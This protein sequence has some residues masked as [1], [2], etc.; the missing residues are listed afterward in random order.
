[1]AISNKRAGVILL[2]SVIAVN[3]LLFFGFSWLYAQVPDG[4]LQSTYTNVATIG[5]VAAGLSMVG[6][7]M[8]I[9]NGKAMMQARGAYGRFAGIFFV[10]AHGLILMAS[11]CIGIASGFSPSDFARFLGAVFTA[12]I[13][14]GFSMVTLFLNTLFGWELA[15]SD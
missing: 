10:L 14:L 2:C 3:A 11:L 8:I 12:I 4:G 5:S 13:A 7:G 1:M 15:Q 6:F 9:G